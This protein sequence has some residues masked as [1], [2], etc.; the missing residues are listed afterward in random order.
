MGLK[1]SRPV[2][3][4]VNLV[5]RRRLYSFCNYFGFPL[6]LANSFVIA[7]W[8]SLTF[9]NGKSGAFIYLAGFSWI[10]F[11]ILS[12]HA[13]FTLGVGCKCTE[14]GT[15]FQCAHNFCKFQAVHCF[16]LAAKHMFQNGVW[17]GEHRTILCRYSTQALVPEHQVWTAPYTSNAFMDMAEIKMC[18]KI[19]RSVKTPWHRPSIMGVACS[20]LWAP[21]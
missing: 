6:T 8:I 12:C 5:S 9:R 13:A 1:T 16:V 11:E 21:E 18:L 4:D 19:N 15:G 7:L 14:V 17:Q 20:R 3:D 2:N 10:L